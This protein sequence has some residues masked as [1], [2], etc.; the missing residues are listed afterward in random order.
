MSI[1]DIISSHIILT[2]VCKNETLSASFQQ[3]PEQ[4]MPQGKQSIIKY[5]L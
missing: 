5:L 2:F 3:T 1:M 4:Q